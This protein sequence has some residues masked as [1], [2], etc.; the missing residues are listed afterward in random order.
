MPKIKEKIEDWE[1]DERAE[2]RKVAKI[3]YKM[4]NQNEKKDNKKND[5][6][7]A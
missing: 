4:K 2:K 6:G 3:K 1:K 5:T 7:S